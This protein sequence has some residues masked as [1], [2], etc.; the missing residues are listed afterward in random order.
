VIIVLIGV[1]EGTE[2]AF[3]LQLIQCCGWSEKSWSVEVEFVLV[4]IECYFSLLL[5]RT[6]LVMWPT[7]TTVN[8]NCAHANRK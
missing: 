2:F 1:W 3:L 8:L 4:I 7:I 6:L 5:Q